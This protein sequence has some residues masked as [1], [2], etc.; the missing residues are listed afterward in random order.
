M[1]LTLRRKQFG[2]F[3]R[4]GKNPSDNNTLHTE[5]QAARVF[6]LTCFSPRPGERWRYPSELGIENNNETIE[7]KHLPRSVRACFHGITLS[8]VGLAAGGL[9]ANVVD[10][11]I[12]VMGKGIPLWL[13]P[14]L[15][16]IW[17]PGIVGIVLGYYAIMRY[18]YLS[19]AMEWTPTL[20][21]TKWL[22]VTLG[23]V[24]WVLGGI[25]GFVCIVTAFDRQIDIAGLFCCGYTSAA[26]FFGGFLLTRFNRDRH[27]TV[28]TFIILTFGYGI[29]AAPLYFPALLIGSIRCR[30]FLASIE[31]NQVGPDATDRILSQCHGKPTTR[32]DG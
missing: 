3:P 4:L 31:F 20:T 10:N 16:V 1:V 18:P 13:W 17:T 29:A 11:F 27:P 22:W 25:A 9:I 8:L 15:I 28:A 32:L 5:P 6:L 7:H 2:H 24:F 19:L 23:W 26:C 12:P 14:I 30:K 21:S